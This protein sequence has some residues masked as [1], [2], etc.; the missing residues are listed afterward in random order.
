MN[1][2]FPDFKKNKLIP[3]VIQEFYSKEVLML[4]Y[5][6]KESF[7]NTISSGWV[8]FWSRSRNKLWQ[9]GEKSGNKLKIKNIYIDCDRDTLLINV[10]LIGKYACHQGTKTCFTKFT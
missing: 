5:M 4:G 1:K 9:K 3:A 6:N 10:E 8:W 2:I 7:K